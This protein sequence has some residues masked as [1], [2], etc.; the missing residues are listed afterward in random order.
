M[1]RNA[2]YLNTKL[3]AEKKNQNEE[4]T[5]VNQNC[6]NDIIRESKH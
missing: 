3:V 6:Q 2:E 5:L 4:K 1:L